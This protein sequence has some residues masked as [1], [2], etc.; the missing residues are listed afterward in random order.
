[1]G[2]QRQNGYSATV[3]AHLLV[4][5]KSVEVAKTSSDVIFVAND[6]ELPPGVKAQLV[7]VVDGERF[8]RWIV[9]HAGVVKG[10]REARYS[11]VV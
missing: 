5:D 9:L 10:Q 6:C 2:I 1:M 3:E 11:P 8:A 4:G 7:V